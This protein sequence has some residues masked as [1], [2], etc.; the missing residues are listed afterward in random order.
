MKIDEDDLLLEE[1]D[2]KYTSN[3]SYIKN[4]TMRDY[5]IEGLNWLISLHTRNING[6]LAG[7]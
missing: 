7:F 3:P 4:G 1:I 2:Q 6:I 5:Q